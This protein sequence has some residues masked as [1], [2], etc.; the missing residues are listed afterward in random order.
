MPEDSLTV[1]MGKLDALR[2][3]GIDPYPHTYEPTYR[4]PELVADGR[5]GL[6]V[7][8]AGRIMASRK[9]GKA[10]FLDITDK[11]TKIQVYLRA[12]ELGPAYNTLNLLDLGDVIGIEG[13]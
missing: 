8:V 10:A 1:R 9:M 7:K 4:V 12:D 5:E 11:Q 3:S 6:E 13:V 2:G